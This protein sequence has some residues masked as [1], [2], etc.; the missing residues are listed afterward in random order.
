M[1]NYFFLKNM[2]NYL[3]VYLVENKEAILFNKKK[4]KANLKDMIDSI[5]RLSWIWF[6]SCEDRSKSYIF[7]SSIELLFILS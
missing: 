6:I 1:F 7:F 4:K 2:V 5:N 3:L